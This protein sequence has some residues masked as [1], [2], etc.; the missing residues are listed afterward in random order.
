MSHGQVVVDGGFQR[1][2]LKLKSVIGPRTV[3]GILIKYES[4]EYIHLTA[5]LFKKHCGL[6][7]LFKH[8]S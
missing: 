5:E 6:Y 4:V 2:A 1:P 8:L 7:Y 3:K